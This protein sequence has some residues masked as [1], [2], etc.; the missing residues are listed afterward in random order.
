[1]YPY[2]SYSKIVNSD[3]WIFWIKDPENS[4]RYTTLENWLQGY[5]MSLH[6]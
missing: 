3:K 2:L 6:S 5:R 4:N 1:M